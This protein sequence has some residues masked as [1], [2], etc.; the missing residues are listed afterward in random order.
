MA[1]V[2]SGG[3]SSPSPVDGGIGC[4]VAVVA[5]S[6]DD[7]GTKPSTA[8]KTK[9]CSPG[10][11][12]SSSVSTTMISP[13][14]NS[15]YRIFSRQRVLDHAL[16]RT[17]QRAGAELRVVARVGEQFLGRL[18]ELDAETLALELAGEPLGHQVDHL[19]DLVA[20]Q[21]VEDDDLVD[22]VQELGPEVRL[23]RSVTLS[24]MR[25]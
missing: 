21:L 9:R 3:G 14:W 16:D 22:A 4:S 25:S 5:S 2:S 20:S 6:T 24:F 7:G 23:Q 19:H 10:L 1:Q 15:L 12:G 11:S 8:V 17:A 18:R 13:A